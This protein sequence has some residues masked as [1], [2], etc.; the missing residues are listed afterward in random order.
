MRKIYNVRCPCLK[1]KKNHPFRVC[2]S[3]IVA[4]TSYDHPYCEN[5]G[6]TKQQEHFS[7]NN[8]KDISYL[9]NR[10]YIQLIAFNKETD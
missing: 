8:G 7:L 9:V 2:Q 10:K 1:C 4:R 3:Q 5:I 6:H